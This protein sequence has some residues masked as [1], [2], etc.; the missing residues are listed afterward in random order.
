M[1]VTVTLSG[2]YIGNGNGAK[3][4]IGNYRKHPANFDAAAKAGTYYAKRDNQNYVIIW[5]SRYGCG[6]W[7]VMAVD[8]LHRLPCLDGRYNCAV[9]K[10]DG[11]VVK[12]IAVYEVVKTGNSQDVG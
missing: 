6:L 5:G 7:W 4:P 9:A 8:Q 1:K 2:E 10:P 11:D 3:A 12:G